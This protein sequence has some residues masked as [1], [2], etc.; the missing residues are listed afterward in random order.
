MGATQPLIPIFKSE[1]YEFWSIRMKTLLKSQDL[2]EF[3]ESGYTEPNVDAVLTTDEEP[4][5]KEKRKKDAKALAI[6]QQAVHDTV[7]S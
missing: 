3:V 5:L 7:F 2:W 6:I 4:K 1:N